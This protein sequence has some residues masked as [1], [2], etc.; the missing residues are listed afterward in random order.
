LSKCSHVGHQV[1][2]GNEHARREP[3]RFEHRDRLS[4]LDEESLVV[5]ETIESLDNF[6]EA[7]P[8]TG[9]LAA[10][11]VDDQFSGLLSNLGIE[12]VHQHPLRCFLNPATRGAGVAA[13]RANRRCLLA[14]RDPL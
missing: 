10:A 1:R 14:H 7:L 6:M 4:R 11:A 3:L 13:R 12:I 2:V 9:R 8:V 5:L